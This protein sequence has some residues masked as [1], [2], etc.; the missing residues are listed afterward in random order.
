M[1]YL[2]CNSSHLMHTMSIPPDQDSSEQVV[3]VL[4][5]KNFTA[6]Q[7]ASGKVNTKQVVKILKHFIRSSCCCIA[8][9]YWEW[10]CVWSVRERRAQGRVE[11]AGT[12]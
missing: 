7:T 6:V 5:A 10:F 3:Q 12:A 2:R 11:G 8:A 9:V 4:A 1:Q